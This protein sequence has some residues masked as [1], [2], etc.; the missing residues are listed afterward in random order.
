[1]GGVVTWMLFATVSVPSLIPN[2]DNLN[3][4]DER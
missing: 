4:R 1:M 2:Q 3:A